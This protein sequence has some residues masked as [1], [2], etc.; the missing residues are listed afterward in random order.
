M[1]IHT[2]ELPR[3]AWSDNV[4]SLEEGG[5]VGVTSNLDWVIP[6]KKSALMILVTISTRFTSITS[7]TKISIVDTVDD[8]L[9][10]NTL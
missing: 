2:D 1:C 3:Q 7:L 4:L 9:H 6:N 8:R 10:T 5:G